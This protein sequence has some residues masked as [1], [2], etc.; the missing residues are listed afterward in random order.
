MTQ[1]SVTRLALADNSA[2]STNAI[3]VSFREC[4]LVGQRTFVREDG[5]RGS[6]QRRSCRARISSDVSSGAIS[7]YFGPTEIDWILGRIVGSVGGATGS[8]TA[9]SPWLPAE[10]LTKFYALVDKG[11]AKFL[12]EIWPSTLQISGSETQYI[13]W[14]LNATGKAETTYGG[15][16]P[17]V[18]ETCEKAFLFSDAV[19]TYNSTEYKIKSFQ[20]SINN[21]IDDQNFQNAI[22]PS[23]FEAQDLE[24]TLQVDCVYNSDNAALYRAALAGAAAKLA[25]T[26]GVTTYN[27]QCGNAKIPNG[28]PTIPASGR[29][30]FPV[31]MEW[32][33]SSTVVS[34]TAADAQL[35]MWKVT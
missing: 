6:R 20:F 34:P 17:A 2:I 22:T 12:Y 18:A 4:G 14:T 11:V 19:L 21:M 10:A 30:T 5:H 26:D 29:L 31:Q 25:I 15:S 13:N 35:Q 24:V 28:G 16:W 7:G 33:R 1:S 23:D 9:G 27:F 3:S 8:G 32:Y